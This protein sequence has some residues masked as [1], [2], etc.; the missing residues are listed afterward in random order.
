MSRNFEWE[1]RQSNFRPEDLPKP[2]LKSYAFREWTL[3]EIPHG[4]KGTDLWVECNPP[5]EFEIW[6]A[7]LNWQDALETREQDW[8]CMGPGFWASE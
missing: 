4:L 7:Q 5:N 1:V 8:E 6:R 2:I 3:W